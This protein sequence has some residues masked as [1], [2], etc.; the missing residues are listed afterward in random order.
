MSILSQFREFFQFGTARGVGHTNVLIDILQ[1]NPDAV[2]L[3][4][5]AHFGD[6]LSRQYGIDRSRFISVRNGTSALRGRFINGPIVVDLPAIADILEQIQY[7]VE[8]EGEDNSLRLE[9]DAAREANHRIVET[10]IE[11]QDRLNDEKR[12]TVKLEDELV[13]SRHD[14]NLAL[15]RVNELKSRLEDMHTIIRGAVH[16]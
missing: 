10:N 6:E 4:H 7:D 1:R 12:Y 3:V 2:M 5:A 15:Q 16:I 13:V 11:L 14:T 9:R 8:K